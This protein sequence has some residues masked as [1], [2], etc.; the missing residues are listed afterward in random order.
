MLILTLRTDKSESEIGL[1]DDERQLAYEVWSA[2]RALAETIHQKIDELLKSQGKK[3]VEIGGIAAFA[4]PGS[5]TGLRIGL[6]VA[7]ALAYSLDIP[8]IGIEGEANW[9]Q[10][11]VAGLKSGQNDTSVIPK[12]GADV[13]ITLPKH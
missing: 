9:L 2:H 7:N 10:K 8:I 11:G 5:F 4:G 6:S 1:F 12:Y 13:H 3:A